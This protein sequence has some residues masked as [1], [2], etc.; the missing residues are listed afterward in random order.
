MLETQIDNKTKKIRKKV[1]TPSKSTGTRKGTSTWLGTL[2]IE[3]HQFAF[4]K[5]TFSDA[6]DLSHGWQSNGLSTTCSCGTANS[7]KH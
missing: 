1:Q 2:A 4:H 6:L 5:G 7:V 3:E